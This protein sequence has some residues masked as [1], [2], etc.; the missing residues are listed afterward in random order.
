MDLIATTLDAQYQI[1]QAYEMS[2]G[3]YDIGV[4]VFGERFN[5]LEY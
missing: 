1:E 2:G 3:G 4:S 5:R